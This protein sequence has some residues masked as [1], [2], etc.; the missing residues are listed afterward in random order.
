M[1][2]SRFLFLT[3]VALPLLISFVLSIWNVGSSLLS[4]PSYA[5]H[6]DNKPS[7]I[8]VV[9]AVHKPSTSTNRSTS[10]TCQL[11]DGRYATLWEAPDF[12][13]V[14][15]QKAGTTALYNLLHKHPDLLRS[16]R[17]EPHF[18]DSIYIDPSKTPTPEKLCDFR[19]R[20][21]QQWPHEQLS[22]NSSRA[23][24]FAFEK[25]PSYLAL[26]YVP[27]NIVRVCPWK[28]KII[29]VLRNPIE[30]AFS[31][32][33]MAEGRPGREH[34][35]FEEYVESCIENWQKWGF[36]TSL[37]KF[38]ASMW[39]GLPDSAFDRNHRFNDILMN[40]TAKTKSKG[41]D[42]LVRGLYAQQ[43]K[44]WMKHFKLGEDLLVIQYEKF[45]KNST[46][47]MNELIN[48]VGATSFGDGHLSSKD[49]EKD[50]GP[51]NKGGKSPKMQMSNV[52][53]KALQRLYQPYNDDLADLLGEE[54]RGIWD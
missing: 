25:T 51:G 49:L 44:F 34:E 6:V 14:G 1:A 10:Y 7:Y 40:I 31:Q 48:F 52:T 36:T 20:Y 53:R 42:P 38:N 33:Q 5:T 45:R 4:F 11:S 9:P 2:P 3:S 47:I 19:F 46:V 27:G 15:A 29:V 26:P 39:L 18:F 17:T 8:G 35:P 32:Y 24:V 43:L 54:W 12:I 22:Q 37:P 30:R 50:Y 41:R 16:V 23:P 28:P 13:I 21:S